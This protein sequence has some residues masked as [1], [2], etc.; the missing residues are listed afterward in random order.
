MLERPE[1]IRKIRMDYR[2]A[3]DAKKDH[4]EAIVYCV[5]QNPECTSAEFYYAIYPLHALSLKVDSPQTQLKLFG[6]I[7]FLGGKE[8]WRIDKHNIVKDSRFVDERVIAVKRALKQLNGRITIFMAQGFAVGQDALD[9]IPR[10]KR[11]IKGIENE[12][13]DY[14]K[15][16]HDANLGRRLAEKKRRRAREVQRP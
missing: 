9:A 2:A 1:K 13:G 15:R 6:K 7:K 4:L 12:I 8:L 14:A 16:A 10:R 5:E 11:T 3:K